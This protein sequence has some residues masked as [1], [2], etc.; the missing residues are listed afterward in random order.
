MQLPCNPPEWFGFEENPENPARAR[1]GSKPSGYHETVAPHTLNWQSKLILLLVLPYAAVSIAFQLPDWLRTAPLAAVWA[2]GIAAVLGLFAWK[3]RS[4]TPAAAVTGAV[5]TASLML[6]TLVFPYRPWQTAL[7]PVVALLLL[8]GFATRFGRA[9]KERLGTAEKPHGRGAAQVA[10]NVGLAALVTEPAMVS[11]IGD[12]LHLRSAGLVFAVGLAALAEAAADT[13]SS[14]LGQVL[15]GQ[16][17]MITTLGRVAPG[18]DG[19]ITP[20]GS[21]AGILAAGVVAG[22]GSFAL[23]GGLGMFWIAWGGGVFGLFFD[24]LLGATLERRGWL[25]NDAVNFLSTASTAVVSIFAI[26]LDPQFR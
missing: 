3:T 12:A 17:R 20:A 6:S 24:S 21:V 5:L 8:T 10:A 26:G 1:V 25:N 9:R 13:V 15:G 16:P 4:A 14:E 7:V 11:W 23:H 18:T 2:I 19:G 22:A